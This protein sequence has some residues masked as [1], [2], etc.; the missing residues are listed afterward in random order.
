MPLDS[1]VYNYG[2][3]PSV[4]TSSGQSPDTLLLAE[5]VLQPVHDGA[6]DKIV[7]SPDWVLGVLVLIFLLLA[8]VRV[9]HLKRLNQLLQAFLYKLHVYTL[10]RSND[11]MLKRINWGLNAI[12]VLTM[13]LFLYQLMEHY[14]VTLPFTETIN[15]FLLI[16][17]VLLVL[18]PV[19]SL[20]LQ[21]VGWIFNDSEKITEYIFNVFLINKVLGLFLVPI[22][23]LAAYLSFGQAMLL[24]AGVGLVVLCYMYRLLR[25]YLI[26]RATATLS[27]FYIFLYLCTLEILP[28]IIIA[29]FVSSEL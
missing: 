22:V 12:F 19:K 23:V 21:L 2:Y 8:W 13:S 28:L 14:G 5:H 11:S 4:D 18:Y 17:P 26:G 9:Y 25:G 24:H 16:V 10:L 7:S 29:K 27:S 15:H 1:N 20:V 6:I 3:A